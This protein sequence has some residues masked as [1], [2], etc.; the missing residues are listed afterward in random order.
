[1]V[2]T[3]PAKKRKRFTEEEDNAIYEGVERYRVGQWAQIKAFRPVELVDRTAN[4]IKDRWR[5]L[6]E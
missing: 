2:D 4:N 6:N 1:M 3:P 5:T